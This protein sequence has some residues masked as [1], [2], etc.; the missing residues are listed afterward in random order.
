M[1]DKKDPKDLSSRK[2][3]IKNPSKYGGLSKGS[4]EGRRKLDAL[5]FDPI[6]RM[7]SLYLTLEDEINHSHHNKSHVFVTTQRGHQKAILS[8]LIPY[9]YH[10]QEVESIKDAIKDSPPPVVIQLPESL[11]QKR[12]RPEKEKK[13]EQEQ[14]EQEKS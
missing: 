13:E 3:D 8:D 6:E 4:K 12:G 7:V 1:T 2:M 11:P 14:G 9:A 5:N 10:K